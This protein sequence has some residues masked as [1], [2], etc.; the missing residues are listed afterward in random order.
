MRG[1]ETGGYCGSLQV[2]GSHGSDGAGGSRGGEGVGCV[3]G[4]VESTELTDASHVAGE[5]RGR[6]DS[7]KTCR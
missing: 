4:K 1:R 5:V 7:T 2:K 3:C 6:R